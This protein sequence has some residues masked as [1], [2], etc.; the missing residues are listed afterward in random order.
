MEHTIQ[1]YLV[2]GYAG[3]GKDT[4]VNFCLEELGPFG[5]EFS[6]VD[7]IKRMAIEYG[8]NGEKDE[9]SRDSLAAI[10]KIIDTWLDGSEASIAKEICYLQSEQDY[11]GLRP[12][13]LVL[14]VYLREINNIKKIVKNLNAKTIFVSRDQKS[15]EKAAFTNE[16]DK[17]VENYS[18]DFYIENNGTLEELKQL[19]QTFVKDFIKKESWKNEHWNY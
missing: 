1:L 7:P 2:N 11:Y 18:Y 9:I 14:F 13:S 3:A 17:N 15:C 12:G 10:K 8:W 5:Y 4:F 19:A 6:T 16:A